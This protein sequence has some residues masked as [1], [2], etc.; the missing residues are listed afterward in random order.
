MEA[1][2]LHLWRWTGILLLAGGVVFWTGAFT[3]PYKWWMTR[4]TR[5]YLTLIYQHKTAWYFIAGTFVVGV[6][7]SVIGMQLFSLSL[8][9]A[10]QHVFPQIGA[11]AFSFGSLFWILNLAFRVTVTVWAAMQLA[12]HQALE[13]SFKSWMDWTNVI[14]AIY[15]VL[16]YFAI[17]CMG[18]A[19]FQSQILPAWLAWF[20][21]IFGFGGSLLYMVRLPLFDPPLMVHLPL[22]VAGI[23]ILLKLKDFPV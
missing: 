15:M 22:M 10:G 6:I 13:A 2:D 18:Y 17:G 12:E 16:A 21:M 1:T 7:L 9:R 11:T 4:D 14:F 23:V 3:P 20:L 8:Q 5:E 19:V